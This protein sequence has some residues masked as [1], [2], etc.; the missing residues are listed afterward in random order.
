MRT[1][2]NFISFVL[3]FTFVLFSSNSHSAEIWSWDVE[4]SDVGVL[5]NDT[6]GQQFDNVNDYDGVTVNISSDYA[7]GGSKSIRIG[8][9]SDEA[10]VEL[11]VNFTATQSLYTRKYEYFAPGWEGNWPVGL[12]TS[13]YFTSGTTYHSEKM[14]WQ[15]YDATCNE[16]F[17]MGMNSAIYNLDIEK[18]YAEAEIFSNGLPYIRTGH[19]YKIETWMVLNSGDGVADGILQIWIDDVQ[20]YSNTAVK[21]EDSARGATGGLGGWTSMWFGGNY[22]GAVCGGPD[23][24]V[25]RY[26]D[27]LYLSTT[28]DRTSHTGGGNLGHGVVFTGGGCFR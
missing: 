23:T 19:W 10:G 5:N 16:Q 22:S 26:I 9:P 2:I 17:G 12:K 27:D 25:Y 4:S 20:V 28:L 18:M 24:T 1:I 8:Y 14:I 7:H 21:W 6:T 3:I 11:A 13:R 15:T